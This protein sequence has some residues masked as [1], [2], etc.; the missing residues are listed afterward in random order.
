MQV[1][2]DTL[3]REC[4][5]NRLRVKRQDL[6]PDNGHQQTRKG[7]SCTS[8][9]RTIRHTGSRTVLSVPSLN[10]VAIDEGDA[11]GF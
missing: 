7:N 2:Q 6:F 3:P 1:F 9:H 10:H 11:D 4:D 5:N 8:S